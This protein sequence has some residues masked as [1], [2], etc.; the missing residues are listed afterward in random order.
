MLQEKK[1]GISTK[2]SSFRLRLTEIHPLPE[3]EDFFRIGV[4]AYIKGELLH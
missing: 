2:N 3:E 4:K 1:R